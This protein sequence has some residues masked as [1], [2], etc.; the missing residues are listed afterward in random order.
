MIPPLYSSDG[1]P[2]HAGRQFS[3]LSNQHP[4]F[5]MLGAMEGVVLRAY[6]KDD[7]ANLSKQWTEY[8]LLEVSTRE[9]FRAARVLNLFAGVDNGSEITLAETTGTTDHTPLVVEEE[10]MVAGNAIIFSPT[11]P[12]GLTHTTKMNG[13]RV[14][15][16]CFGGSKTQP[17]IFG[18]LPHTEA[19]YNAT[20]AQSPRVLK[21]INGWTEEFKKDGSLVLQ[22]DDG[23]RIIATADGHLE[24]FPKDGAHL[25]LAG[26][27]FSA[28]RGENNNTNISDVLQAISDMISALNTYAA[29]IASVA[30]PFNVA[31]PILVSQLAAVTGN[32]AVIA[33]NLSGALSPV[34]KVP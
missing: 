14:A 13:E 28:V 10:D 27:Q 32:L 9:R 3:I 25:R 18:A 29:A 4:L 20:R 8:D 23:R 19:A 21:K 34:P 7:A 31:T 22:H 33:G 12:L 11:S 5:S 26:T 6:F 17:V 2:F 15:F 30:D 1:T 24:L 16:I